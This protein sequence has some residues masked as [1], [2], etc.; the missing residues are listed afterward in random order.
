MLLIRK[1]RRVVHYITL[2]VK[3]LQGTTMAQ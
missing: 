2:V 1:V 3:K